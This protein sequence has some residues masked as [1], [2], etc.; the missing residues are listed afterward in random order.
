[1]FIEFNMYFRSLTMWLASR[2]VLEH[3]S[4][5]HKLVTQADIH[6]LT[7]L[8]YLKSSMKANYK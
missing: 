1:M 8:K 6:T 3:K 7:T 2:W 4:S 5:L